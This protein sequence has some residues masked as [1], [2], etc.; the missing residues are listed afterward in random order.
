MTVFKLKKL[1][2]TTELAHG[3]GYSG[4]VIEANIL[5][6]CL[7]IFPYLPREISGDFTK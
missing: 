1:Y 3:V 4:Q 5:V 2:S 7:L 6:L